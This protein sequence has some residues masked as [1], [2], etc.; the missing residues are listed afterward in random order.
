MR[1][2]APEEV[3]LKLELAE[4]DVARL[5]RHPWLAE[6]SEGRPL[7]RALRSVY[8]DT[9]DLALWR[10]GLVLRVREVGGHRIV[11][12]KTRGSARGGLVAREEVEA[13]LASD[14]PELRRLPRAL[15]LG[16]IPDARLQGAIE[17]AAAGKRLA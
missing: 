11:G 2:T 3:E 15:L 13:A 4:S 12:V 14:V 6:I 7:T 16:A 8:F 5:A 17:R 9:P 1:S 10:R